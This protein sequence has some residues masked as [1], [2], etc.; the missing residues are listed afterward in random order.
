MNILNTQ[1]IA[2]TFILCGAEENIPIS[3][4]KLQKLTYFFYKDYLKVTGHALFSEPFEK[5][6]Y[7]PVLPS[8]YYEF[9]SFGAN[10]ITRFAKDAKGQAE[11]INLQADNRI[12]ASFKRIWQKYKGFDAI[13]LSELTHKKGSAW[14][15]T[16]NT[17]ISNE[18][19]KN[20][21]DW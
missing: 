20:E 5:W 9:N 6:T 4:M 8:L 2:N 21:E 11:I 1:T 12:S 3:P 14:D 17:I 18:D 10:N 15:K 16:K 13:S 7:G 19:I